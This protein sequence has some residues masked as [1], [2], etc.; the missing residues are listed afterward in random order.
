MGFWELEGKNDV[1]VI[2]GLLE[3]WLLIDANSCG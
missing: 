3:E 2:I 1:G